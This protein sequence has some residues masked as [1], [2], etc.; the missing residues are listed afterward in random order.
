[1][2]K[3]AQVRMR[4]E[5][6]LKEE[7]ERVLESL[8]LTPSAAINMFYRQIVHRRSIPFDVALPEDGSQPG[9]AGRT[10]TWRRPSDGRGLEYGDFPRLP[11]DARP[12]APLNLD[13]PATLARFLTH[14]DPE[15]T[16]SVVTLSEIAERLPELP[17]RP[18]TR[19]SWECVVTVDDC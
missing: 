18:E 4:T 1:M 9:G 16:A 6:A 19:A 5:A 8:G 11:W 12:D 15:T 17:L 3:D 7:A 14:A 10:K 13:D 2:T